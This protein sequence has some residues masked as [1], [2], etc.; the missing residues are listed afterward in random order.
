MAGQ[1]DYLPDFR[2]RRIFEVRKGNSVS[3]TACYTNAE[4]RAFQRRFNANEL[5]IPLGNRF[6]GEWTHDG[7]ITPVSAPT[8]TSTQ[9]ASNPAYI[10]RF[11]DRFVPLVRPMARKLNIDEN[12]L[13]ALIVGEHGWAPDPGHNDLFHNLFGVTDAGGPNLHWQSDQQACDYWI[14]NYGSYVKN[15]TSFGQ[16]A[17]ILISHKYNVYGRYKQHLLDSYA[18]VLRHKPRWQA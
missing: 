11:F 16:F 4:A 6:G 5:R 1:L 18:S 8:G 12:Y 15:S 14:E 2:E 7:S 10:D 3:F 17:D 9:P 13:L